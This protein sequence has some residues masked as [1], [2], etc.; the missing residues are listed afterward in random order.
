MCFDVF[1]FFGMEKNG[2]WKYIIDIECY[3][4]VF[5]YKGYNCCFFFV[6]YVMVKCLMFLNV[7][8]FVFFGVNDIW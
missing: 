7:W 5:V 3:G 6:F 1:W 4:F 8:N 2:K